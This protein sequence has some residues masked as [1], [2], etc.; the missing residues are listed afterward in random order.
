M[1]K[2]YLLLPFLA[3]MSCSTVAEDTSDFDNPILVTKMV[4]DGD[5][6]TFSYSGAKITEMRNTTDNWKRVFTYSGD[7]I[8]KFVD[9]LPDNSTQTTTITYNSNNKITKKT[10]VYSAVPS[11]TDTTTYTY[12]GGDKIKII[13]TIAATGSTKTYT[14]DAVTNPDN[15]LKNWE[16]NVSWV[17]GSTTTTG[18]GTLQ[19]IT[20]DGGSFPFKN[21]TGYTKL[22]LVTEDLNVSNRN[23]LRYKN[24]ITYPGTGNE[25]TNFQSS[26]EYHTNGYPKKDVRDYYDENDMATS[27][28][29]TTYEYNHL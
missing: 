29:I 5:N 17:Q 23:V 11:Q 8:T 16:E 21:V 10:T 20:Y 24:I 6:Y 27:S 3:V 1:K 15:S 26:Y 18:N 19:T 4:Q 28:E 12:I 13:T 7:L 9:T 22:L 2:F 25:Y 14:K